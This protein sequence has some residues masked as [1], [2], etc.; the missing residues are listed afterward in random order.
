M[1]KIDALKIQKHESGRKEFKEDS[2]T[3]LD[4]YASPRLK[5]QGSIVLKNDFKEDSIPF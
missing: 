5:K 2:L 1:K 4:P 3:S